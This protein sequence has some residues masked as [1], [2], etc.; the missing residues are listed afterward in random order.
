MVRVQ[1]VWEGLGA[2]AD[3]SRLNMQAAGED[4]QWGNYS[5]LVR[6]VSQ[7]NIIL[8]LNGTSVKY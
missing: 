3:A 4:D 8:L 2:A 7:R 1:S 5:L 6:L